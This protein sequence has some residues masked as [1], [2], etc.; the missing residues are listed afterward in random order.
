MKSKNNNNTGGDGQQQL[1]RSARI[2]K[3]NQLVNEDKPAAGGE[4]QPAEDCSSS[5]KNRKEDGN[6]LDLQV[7]IFLCK[8]AENRYLFSRSRHI[9]YEL[10]L[11]LKLGLYRYEKEKV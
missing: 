6:N 7:Y 8:R 10:E 11:K 4:V 3:L 2:R 5:K 1:R 9:N